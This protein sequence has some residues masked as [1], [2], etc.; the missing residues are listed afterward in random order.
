MSVSAHGSS[1]ADSPAKGSRARRR[2][3]WTG[4]SLLVLGVY[5]SSV[6]WMGHRVADDV[7]NGM[8][9]IDTAVVFPESNR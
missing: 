5:F 7:R 9:D 6:V 3:I 1:P 8:R 2:L 4:A